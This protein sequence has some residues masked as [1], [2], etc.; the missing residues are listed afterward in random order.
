VTIEYGIPLWT[1]GGFTSR[2]GRDDL[3]LEGVGAGILRR[4]LPGIVQTT[5]NAGYYSFYPFLLARW[6]D[7]GISVKTSDL[8]PW[9]RRQE[10]VF[11]VASALHEHR[12]NLAGIAGVDAVRR[13]LVD[14]PDVVDLGRLSSSGPGRYLKAGL[15]GLGLYYGAVLKDL[16]LTVEGLGARVDRVTDH[17]RV[18]AES[19]APL[20]EES[21]YF[22]SFREAGVVPTPVLEELGELVCLCAI[23][24][25]SDHQVLLDTFVGDPIEN[26]KWEARRRTRASSI[27]L[28]VEFHAQRP[29]GVDGSLRTWRKALASERFPDGGP[30]TTS[31]PQI[32]ES[33]RAYQIREAESIALLGLWVSFLLRLSE[34]EPAPQAEVTG[35]LVDDVDWSVVEL[36]PGDPTGPAIQALA[37]SLSDAEELIDAASSLERPASVEPSRY[38]VGCLQVLAYCIAESHSDSDGF[39]QLADEGG[40]GRWSLRHLASWFESRR[41]Q[42]IADTLGDLIH[43]LVFQHKRVALGKVSPSGKRDPF[44]VAE[45]DGLLSLIRSDDPIW[46]D[47]RFT[48]VNHL[49]WTLGLLDGPDGASRPTALGAETLKRIVQDA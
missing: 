8:K 28:F 34:V 13:A 20:W 33:W 3:G 16:R 24:G 38:L 25:R 26:P 27:G 2:S 30:W 4:L 23:P 21:S 35:G 44:C 15:G 11:V 5:P 40:S 48:T 42:G 32:R 22:G 18:V 49:L 47:G 7:L 6:E 43:A 36:G 14:Q 37:G 46:S 41:D 19:F 17:G 31:F 45:D 1:T 39:R 9:F 29:D 10:V 12:G